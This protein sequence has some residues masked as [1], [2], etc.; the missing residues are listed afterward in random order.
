MKQS[1]KY[2]TIKEATYTIHAHGNML[3]SIFHRSKK[4]LAINIPENVELYK[5]KCGYN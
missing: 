2:P 3:T 1:V 5:F 4:F